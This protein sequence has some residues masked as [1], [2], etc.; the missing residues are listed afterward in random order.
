MRCTQTSEERMWW[1]RLEKKPWSKNR[2]H[3]YICHSAHLLFLSSPGITWIECLWPPKFTKL[4]RQSWLLKTSP[5]FEIYFWFLLKNCVHTVLTYTHTDT[6]TPNNLTSKEVN[7]LQSF[8]SNKLMWKLSK[9]FL[10][11]IFKN[12]KQNIL[13]LCIFTI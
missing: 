1:D 9:H 6:H 12:W 7:K 10:Q 3:L 5:Q 13:S 8:G 4:S 2:V 11:K